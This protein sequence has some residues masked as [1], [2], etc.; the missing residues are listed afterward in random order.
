MKKETKEKMKQ[1]S[2]VIVIGTSAVIGWELGN[3]LF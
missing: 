2:E 3:L 1:L